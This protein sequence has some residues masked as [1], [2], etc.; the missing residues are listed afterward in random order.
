MMRSHTGRTLFLYVTQLVCLYLFYAD[1]SDV[2]Q[3]LKVGLVFLGFL[4]RNEVLVVT[5]AAV[6]VYRVMNSIRLHY[7]PH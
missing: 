7:T 4:F 6:I 1:V 3:F 2:G 5:L